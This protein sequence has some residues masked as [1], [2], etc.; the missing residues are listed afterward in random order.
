MTMVVP[1]QPST[2][3]PPPGRG[4]PDPVPVAVHLRPA[5][6][7][8]IEERFAATT[9]QPVTTSAAT[10]GSPGSFAAASSSSC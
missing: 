3:A 10:R 8:G 5:R 6:R 7:A 1:P 9:S 4:Q 2:G